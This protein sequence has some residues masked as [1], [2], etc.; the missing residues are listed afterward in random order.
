M[1][2]D[3]KTGLLGRTLSHSISPFLHGELG[4]RSY[5]LFETEP[6]DLE[7]FLSSDVWDCLNVTIPYKQAVIPFCTALTERAKAA[8]AVNVLLKKDGKLYGDN[9]DVEGFRALVDG[10]DFV[11]RKTVIL[12]KGGAA[13]MAR[14]VCLDKGAS[15]VLFVSRSGEIR[16]SDTARYCDAEILIN[17]TPVGMYPNTNESPVDLS[18]FSKLKHVVDL[19]ANPLRTALCLEAESRGI[20]ARGGLLMLAVQAHEAQC[21]FRSDAPA[22]SRQEL[23]RRALCHSLHIVLVGMPGCGKSTLGQ[24]LSEQLS[25]P[26]FD[27]DTLIEE[28]VGCS[29]PE[30]FRTKG[31]AY[32]REVETQV[33]RELSAADA[34]I[35]ATGGGAVLKDENRR[36]LKQNGLV[37]HL[38]CPVEEL[39]REGRPLS[40]DAEALKRM[41][42]ER[43]AC[44]RAARD[45]HFSFSKHETDVGARL[46]KQIKTHLEEL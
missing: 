7:V 37:V 17:A 27:T 15:E 18:L 20:D 32:F 35:V 23:Y 41:A 43:E 19:V 6:E 46:F 24:R 44:Y 28:R 21:V 22:I 9:T 12:G 5:R 40:T 16:F 4:D 2:A 33:L 1:S 8:G 30:L 11:T 29:I 39:S 10:I 26:L 45:L 13:H 3:L 36:L 42:A 34:C 25:L 14:A 38:D 31:E